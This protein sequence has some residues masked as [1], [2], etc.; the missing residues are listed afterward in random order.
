MRKATVLIAEDERTAR[1]SLAGLLEAEGFRVLTA[2]NGTLALSLL[3][4][5]EPEAAILDIRMPGMDGLTVLRRA[6]EGG[7]DS[8]LIVM[9]AQGDSGTAIDAM[10]LGAFDYV[11]KPLDF[12]V[13]LTQVERAIE[14]RRLARE[15]R[16]APGA[17]P[18]PTI[19]K[20]MVGHS[21][22]MQHVYK[23]IGQ[24]ATSDATVL[25]RGE[26]GTGKE[27]VVNAIHHNSAR[28]QGPLIKVN[29]A[30]IPE[31]LLESELFGHEKGA[32]TNA[33]FRRVGRFEEANK[34]TLFLDEIGEMAPALQSKL[35]RA[36]QERIIERLGS[37]TP[38]PVDI[39]LVTATSRDLERAVNEG[40]FREDLY[41][42]LN[43]VAVPLPP[44]RERLQDIPALVQHFL[45][46]SGSRVSITAPALA[47]LCEYHWPGNVRELENAVERT[48]VLARSGVIT[49][50]EIQLRTLQEPPDT[51]WS[52]RAPLEEGLKANV[53]VLEKGLIERALRQA[54]GNKTRAAE[55]LGVHRRLLYEKIREYGLEAG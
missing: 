19:S 55:I 28:A 37:N 39:R 34:G 12:K 22:A 45:N 24:V 44:L 36:L 15:L 31:T 3:L 30:S 10:K 54:Q 18:V 26:S 20:T 53:A 17:G 51:K 4:T 23:L 11:S 7:S 32:F 46:R 38:I 49:E 25:V 9:T 5:E 13:L 27:L 35:L 16:A 41:Y 14:Q 21:P 1:T 2:E 47:L 33:L 48:L 40:S 43:V 50:D 29:C 8:A 42:R 52:D 6:R